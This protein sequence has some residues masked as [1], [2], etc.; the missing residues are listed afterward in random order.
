M[1]T[2]CE[3]TQRGVAIRGCVVW[4]LG[5]E[6]VFQELFRA[7]LVTILSIEPDSSML[8]PI[9]E[10]SSTR[11]HQSRPQNLRSVVRNPTRIGH[12]QGNNL[13]HPITFSLDSGYFKELF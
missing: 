8:A 7:I 6:V 12:M 2:E 1:E 4:I 11:G 10:P 3:E 13:L 9:M 5:V